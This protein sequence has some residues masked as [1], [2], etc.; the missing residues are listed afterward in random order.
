MLGDEEVEGKD[1]FVE[2]CKSFGGA[3]S[4]MRLVDKITE[5]SEEE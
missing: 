1:A 4:I 2:F 3:K 5:D